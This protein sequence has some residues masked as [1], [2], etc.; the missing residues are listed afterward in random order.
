MNYYTFAD[1][2][3]GQS[4]GYS[5]TVS[6][7]MLDQFMKITKDVNPL[8]TDEQTAIKHGFR[9]RVS[10]GMLTASFLSA[11]AGVYLPGRYSLIQGVD[12]YFVKPVYTGDELTVLGT[13]DELH[14]SVQQIVLKVV[15]SNQN[16][17]K[18]LRG[19]MKVGLL[20]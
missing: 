15:I 18:V 19:R 6:E 8:H 4:E 9:K 20:K 12:V 11:L 17:E 1:L 3:T 16:N 13:V 5:I 10:Y 7:N 2:K 14:P